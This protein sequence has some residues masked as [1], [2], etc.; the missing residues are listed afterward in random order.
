V[1]AKLVHAP[2]ELIARYDPDLGAGLLG[3]KMHSMIFDNSQ[4]KRLVPQ[5][6]PSIPFWRGAEEIIAWYDADP[7]RQVVDPAYDALHDRI[8]QPLESCKPSD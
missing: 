5:F 8:I 2:S 1:D 7:A 3:D 4:I 6:Q